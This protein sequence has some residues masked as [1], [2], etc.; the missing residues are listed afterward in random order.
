MGH[1]DIQMA[2]NVYGHLDVQR[3]QDVAAKLSGTLDEGGRTRRKITL[4]RQK[5]KVL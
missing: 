4:P 3:K 2:A 5:E 1:S